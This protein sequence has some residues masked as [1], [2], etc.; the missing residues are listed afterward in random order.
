MNIEEINAVI[1]SIE[2]AWVVRA[3]CLGI[4]PSHMEYKNSEVE[5]FVGAMAALNAIYPNKDKPGTLSEAVPPR[6][7]LFP[8][9]GRLIVDRYRI[10]RTKAISLVERANHLVWNDNNADE[11]V[12]AMAEKYILEGDSG[13]FLSYVESLPPG[14]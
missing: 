8:G 5:F 4:N 7:T 12:K 2:T 11:G 1:K 13:E 14:E 10:N 9:M 6:W 3:E